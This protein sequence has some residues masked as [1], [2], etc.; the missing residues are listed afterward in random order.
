MLWNSTN[1]IIIYIPVNIYTVYIYRY[2]YIYKF[3][4]LIAFLQQAIKSISCYFIPVLRA[5]IKEKTNTHRNTTHKKNHS[6]QGKQCFP[7]AP[8]FFCF[9]LSLPFPSSFY[10]LKN[11]ASLLFSSLLRLPIFCGRC[12]AT[13]NPLAPPPSPKKTNWKNKKKTR[14]RSA[15]YSCFPSSP[16]LP[17]PLPVFS[18][19]HTS[20]QYKTISF[21]RF[22]L[23]FDYPNTPSQY[24]PS[25]YKK[26]KN[27]NPIAV[28][29][30]M[31][32]KIVNI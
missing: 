27:E 25:L 2:V 21:F 7:F 30:G 13:L 24:R 31:N 15:T 32:Y 29:H 28:V 19:P 23:F 12:F 14:R 9:S 6:L 22:F 11:S 20:E 5:P 18:L 4:Y 26:K 1:H 3:I 16:P 10:F 17:T 8:F